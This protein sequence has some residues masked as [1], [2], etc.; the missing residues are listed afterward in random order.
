ML[1]AM[2]SAC[3]E[4]TSAPPRFAWKL[5]TLITVLRSPAELPLTLVDA[6]LENAEKQGYS[7]RAATVAASGI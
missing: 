5:E 7:A 1:R 3:P 6:Y 4:P 2:S